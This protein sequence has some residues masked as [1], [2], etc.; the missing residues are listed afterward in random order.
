MRNL[1][2]IVHE[3]AYQAVTDQLRA[4]DIT[5]FTVSHVEGHGSHTAEHQFLSERDRVV[6]FVPRVR[7]DIVLPSEQLTTVLEALRAPGAGYAGHGTYW[8][9][10]IEQF[11]QF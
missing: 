3:G 2:L 7:V 6:G 4:L 9:S 5:G 8:V 11:G 10:P 1:V